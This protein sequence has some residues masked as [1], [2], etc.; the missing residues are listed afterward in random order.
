MAS[1][2]IKSLELHYTITQVLIIN[3]NHTNC[4]GLIHNL[5]L[6]YFSGENHRDT[7]RAYYGLGCA[8][9]A[10]GSTE[11]ALENLKKARNIQVRVLASEHDIKKTDNEINSLGGRARTGSP[12]RMLQEMHI[13]NHGVTTRCAVTPLTT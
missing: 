7:A 5:S 11:E 2:P 3:N 6:F 13:E 10:L 9:G 8:L 1:K 12:C 4:E